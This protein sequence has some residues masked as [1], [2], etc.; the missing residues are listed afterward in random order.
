VFANGPVFDGTG[1]PSAPAAV[2]VE[3]GRIL[4]IGSRT[5][6]RRGGGPR[7]VMDQHA[8]SVRRAVAAGI[9]RVLDGRPAAGRI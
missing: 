1:L 3:S 8:D 6:R 4:E 5:E 9:R 2:L 7:M